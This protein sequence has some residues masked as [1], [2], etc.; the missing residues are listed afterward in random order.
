[1]ILLTWLLPMTMLQD[2]GLL[3]R[4]LREDEAS[5]KTSDIADRIREAG[6]H[7]VPALSASIAPGALVMRADGSVFLPRESC[8]PDATVSEAF[9][10]LPDSAQQLSAGVSLSL[11]AI[12]QLLG[13]RGDA[14]VERSATITFEGIAVRGVAAGAL[15]P[16]PHCLA[17]L[18]RQRD[19]GIGLDSY[20]LITEVLQA[21][22]VSVSTKSALGVEAATEGWGSMLSGIGGGLA[23]SSQSETGFTVTGLLTLGYRCRQ[24]VGHQ[25]DGDIENSG[26]SSCPE[27]GTP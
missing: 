27:F 8:F 10:A 1:M 3:G 23:I 21:D 14:S 6:F 26:G 9:A 25:A 17:V 20:L 2:R 5:E 22:G 12:G 15:T 4:R 24:L 11:G 18:N 19:A 13:G 16:S 7:A